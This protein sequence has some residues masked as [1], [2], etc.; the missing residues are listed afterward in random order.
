VFLSDRDGTREVC[1][2][3]CAFSTPSFKKQGALVD[4]SVVVVALKFY[5][6]YLH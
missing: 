2:V 1:T 4:G 3:R 5:G 6:E